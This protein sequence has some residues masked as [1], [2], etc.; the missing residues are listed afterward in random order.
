MWVDND[1]EIRFKTLDPRETID[2]YDDT[3]DHNLI[4]GIRFYVNDLSDRRTPEYYVEVYDSLGCKKYKSAPGFRSFEL[5][6]EVPH[7]FGQ[8]PITFF[9]LNKEEDSVFDRVITLQN[10]YNT[11]LSSSIDDWESFC[12]AYLEFKNVIAEEDLIAMKKN[13]TLMLDG[14][15][16]ASYLTKNINDTQIQHLLDLLND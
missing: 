16:D 6:E 14:D 7:Y 10:A 8:V 3:L 9:T 1:G 11:L 4:Y 2:V 15:A 13:R 12:D 5:V